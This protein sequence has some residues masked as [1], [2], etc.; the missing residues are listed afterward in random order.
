MNALSSTSEQSAGMIESLVR[1]SSESPV[2]MMRWKNAPG[3]PVEFV[4]EN[5]THW[6]Y[7]PEEFTEGL[8]DYESIVHPDDVKKMSADA[9]DLLASK[10]TQYA[11]AYR[12]FKANGEVL[13][14]DDRTWV[15]YDN[16]GQIKFISGVLIDMTERIQQEQNLQ[17]AL[18]EKNI[19]LSEVHHRVKNNLA[20]ISGIL[21]LQVDKIETNQ[22]RQIFLDTITKVRS[23]SLIH[24]ALYQNTQINHIPVQEYLPRVVQA[25]Q[26]SFDNGERLIRV[27][28]D[29]DEYS[30]SADEAI[31]L[32]LIANELITNSFK[33][34]FNGM[35]EGQIHIKLVRSEQD[36]TLTIRDNGCGLPLNNLQHNGSIGLSIVEGLAAQL[37]SSITLYNEDGAVARLVRPIN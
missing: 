1:M 27:Y 36:I 23:I 26:E 4:S 16:L 12:I 10:K 24:E 31:P 7:S 17:G 8:R 34:A 14:I 21:Q 3:W 13:W 25:I 5:V 15:E 11:Q 19:L 22:D 20:V 32:G 35:D 28:T 2:V 33:H 18:K 9:R 29:I 37:G 6:G 30:V